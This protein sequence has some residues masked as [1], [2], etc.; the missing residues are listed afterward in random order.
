MS[1][2]RILFIFPACTSFGDKIHMETKGRLQCKLCSRPV[3]SITRMVYNTVKY[4][5]SKSKVYL[6][7]R[8]D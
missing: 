1:G 6:N 2:E 7:L 8:F 5:Q 4:T 3:E